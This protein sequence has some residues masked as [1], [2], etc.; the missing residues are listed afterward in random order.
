MNVCNCSSKKM[1]NENYKRKERKWTKPKILCGPKEPDDKTKE[2]VI[3]RKEF[4]LINAGHSSL[5]VPTS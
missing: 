1:K 3:G 4:I 5:G 2:D